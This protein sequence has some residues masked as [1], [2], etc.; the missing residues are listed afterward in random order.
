MFL[1]NWASLTEVKAKIRPES[2]LR[3]GIVTSDNEEK[4][5]YMHVC[6][7]KIYMRR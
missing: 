6:K 7:K 5:T 3:F 1:V 4:M 2:Y